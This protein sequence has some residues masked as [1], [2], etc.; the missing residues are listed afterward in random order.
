MLLAVAVLCT[1][2]AALAGFSLLG[3]TQ[4]ACWTALMAGTDSCS[5]WWAAACR[6]KLP[7]VV[8]GMHHP[9]RIVAAGW[10]RGS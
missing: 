1:G 10:A 8:S 6:H 3:R 9:G 2:A 7:N 5:P 4:G